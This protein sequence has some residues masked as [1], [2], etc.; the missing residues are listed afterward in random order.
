MEW[1]LNLVT[2]ERGTPVA[3]PVRF[4]K[5]KFILL[6]VFLSWSQQALALKCEKLF[7]PSSIVRSAQ[8]PI[9]SNLDQFMQR[10]TPQR[11][12]TLMSQNLF[13]SVKNLVA[14]TTG[15]RVENKAT[16][17]TQVVEAAL[18]R[19]KEK[20][21]AKKLAL[22]DRDQKTLGL[23]NVTYTEYTQPFAVRLS[24]LKKAGFEIRDEIATNLEKEITVKIRI[25][26]YGTV[27]E[28][29]TQFG[30][31]DITF[32]DFT[33]QR[34][35]VELKFEDPSY[36]GAV[37]KPQAYMKKEFIEL[38]GTPDFIKQYDLIKAETLA[39]LRISP[40]KSLNSETVASLLDFIYEAHKANLNLSIVAMNIYERS[41]KSATLAYDFKQDSSHNP[42]YGEGDTVTLEMTFDQLVSLYL[43]GKANALGEAQYYQ[44]YN[45][46]QT[47][48]EFKTPT[49][50]AHHLK[51]AQDEAKAMGREG[52]VVSEAHAKELEMILPG[53][54]EY[55]EMVDEIIQS[56]D[57]KKPLNR[58]KWGIALKK[59]KAEIENLLN[60]L[61]ADDYQI[62]H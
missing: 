8:D 45:P 53:L 29:K 20:L 10:F 16:A 34:A 57:P 59:V 31:S 35:F 52:L 26:S 50:I 21:A 27:A 43:P 24:A 42:K 17:E 55:F 22:V 54:K 58:G 46:T 6:L 30:I 25:R 14:D 1:D 36:E 47:V 56:R 19:F 9:Q 12:N 32:A 61:Y 33:Q 51:R 13:G 3:N 2:P 40:K 60:Q 5:F 15:Q 39:N 4:L 44:A 37:F 41:A 62:A 49:R 23:R 28:S 48:S 38:F 18:T 7:E 11:I